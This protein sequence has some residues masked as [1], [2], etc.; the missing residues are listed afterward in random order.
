MCSYATLGP[1]RIW[2]TSNCDLQSIYLKDDVLLSTSRIRSLL[3]TMSA[4]LAS[5]V[6]GDAE[7]GLATGKS[8]IAVTLPSRPSASPTETS[9]L[10]SSSTSSTRSSTN[11]KEKLPQILPPLAQLTLRDRPS[12]PPKRLKK[13][14]SRWIRFQLWFNTYRYGNYWCNG[15]HFAE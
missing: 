5:N 1:G 9:T 3:Y 6:I 15:Q 14:S 4:P 13:G 2:Y 10:Y 12:A 8:L 11:E 7:K